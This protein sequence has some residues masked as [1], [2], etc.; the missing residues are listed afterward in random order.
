MLASHKAKSA[1]FYYPACPLAV[2]TWQMTFRVAPLTK[3]K[4]QFSELGT[5]QRPI[6]HL[7]SSSKCKRPEF[8]H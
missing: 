8:Y 6:T 4:Y 1:I 2:N 7:A 3:V 5:L